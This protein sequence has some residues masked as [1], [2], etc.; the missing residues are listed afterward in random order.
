METAQLGDFPPATLESLNAVTY[1]HHFSDGQISLVLKEAGLFDPLEIAGDLLIKSK[2]GV[3]LN[4]YTK[5][6]NS[7]A[8][9]CL[10]DGF[11]KFARWTAV[12]L[13]RMIIEAPACTVQGIDF[14]GGLWAAG[15]FG[16]A[17]A[18]KGTAQV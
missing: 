14:Y 11:F 4:G 1:S 3:T 15:S 18:G 16:R 10:E 5:E 7:I 9:Q 13:R 8:P 17:D 2:Y 6:A 12:S